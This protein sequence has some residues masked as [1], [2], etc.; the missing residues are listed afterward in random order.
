MNFWTRS[1]IVV[2]ILV[3]S[4]L[5]VATFS[6]RERIESFEFPSSPKDTLASDFWLQGIFL[7]YQSTK[8]KRIER[9]HGKILDAED[10]FFFV[11]IIIPND[12]IEKTLE[13][14]KSDSKYA[15]KRYDNMNSEN[16]PLPGYWPDWFP[17]PNPENYVG[18]IKDEHNWT[19]SI[20][21]LGHSNE[22]F[23]RL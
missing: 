6:N 20:Y 10:I 7:G 13:N 17:A 12:E 5:A 2:S 1:T 9:R 11:K 4:L 16:K 8:I 23:L 19:V 21:R 18:T 14:F 15:F 22:L 3:I